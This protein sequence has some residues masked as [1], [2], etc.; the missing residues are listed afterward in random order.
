MSEVNGIN[1]SIEWIKE[2]LERIEERLDA[3]AEKCRERHTE[4]DKELTA[5]KVR[6]GLYGAESSGQRGGPAAAW[7]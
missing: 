6:A 5:L 1:T 2:S 7:S 4:I 3:G